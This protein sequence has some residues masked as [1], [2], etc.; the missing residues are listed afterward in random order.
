[1]VGGAGTRYEAPVGIR[2][3]STAYGLVLMDLRGGDFVVFDEVAAAMWHALVRD[4]Q[5][6]TAAHAAL[7]EAFEVSAD[8]LAADLQ[9]FVRECV[10][11]LW[12]TP[13]RVPGSLGGADA[14]PAYVGRPVRERRPKFLTLDAWWW[15]VRASRL[16]RRKGLAGLS[17]AW[18]RPGMAGP[19][20]AATHA[21]KEL[22]S[23]ALAAFSRAE[24]FY[25]SASAPDD[26][27]RRSLALYR[28]LHQL[29]L[30]V[31]HC[32][33]YESRASGAHAWVECHGRVLLD[34]DRRD[35]L[36]R[37]MPASP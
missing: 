36:T 32:I 6:V 27:L 9:R 23:A 35:H 22:L 12:L 15:L 10:D 26:C 17:G 8:D 18:L 30:P 3:A 34:Q 11:Q 13:R 20:A 24:N 28:F 16:L 19:R 14:A 5:D 31:E 1:M 21:D 7:M 4:G 33:G 37:F 29:G 25:I 2:Q